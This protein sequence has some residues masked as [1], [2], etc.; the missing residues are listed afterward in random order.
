MFSIH[1]YALSFLAQM[2]TEDNMGALNIALGGTNAFEI[3]EDI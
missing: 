3:E 1:E 2:E